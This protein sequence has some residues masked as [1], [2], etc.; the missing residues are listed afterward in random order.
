MNLNFQEVESC[1]GTYLC[2]KPGKIPKRLFT[3][4]DVPKDNNASECV[5]RGFCIGKKNWQMIA[6]LRGASN[7]AIIYSLGLR[8]CLH[9]LESNDKNSIV[10][11]KVV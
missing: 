4:G 1:G 8:N 3:D 2:S 6:I 11:V 9:T 10:T 5:I 7:S